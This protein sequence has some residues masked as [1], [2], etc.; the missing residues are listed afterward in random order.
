MIKVRFLFEAL[1]WYWH[2]ECKEIPFQVS[3]LVIIRFKNTKKKLFVCLIRYTRYVQR[4]C[5]YT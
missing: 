3:L 2:V 4:K 5:M 1:L